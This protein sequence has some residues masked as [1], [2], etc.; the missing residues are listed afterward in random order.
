MLK[1]IG[2]IFA[3]CFFVFCTVSLAMLIMHKGK[4]S[5]ISIAISLVFG[6][7]CLV[8]QLMIKKNNLLKK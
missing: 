8:I 7:L 5:L 2:I 3:L 6:F 4:M 1:K